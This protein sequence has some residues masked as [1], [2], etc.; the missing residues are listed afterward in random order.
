MQQKIIIHGGFFSESSANQAMKQA[1]QDALVEIV[2]KSYQYLHSNSALDTAVYAVSLLEDCE[3]FNA[4]TGSQIQADGK[5]RLSASLMDGSTKNFSGVINIESVKNP[6]QVAFKLQGEEDCVLSGLEATSFARQQGFAEYDPSTP[7]RRNEYEEKLD[8][9][10]GKGTVGCV[11][12][13]KDGNLAAATSTGGKGFERPGRVS[14]SA[15]VAGNYANELAAISCTGIGE[16]IVKG[17]LAAKIVTRVSDGASLMDACDKTLAEMK[18]YN[19][20]A[21]VIGITVDGHIHYKDSHPYMVWAF[22]DGKPVVFPG[23]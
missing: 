9:S 13:D 18:S 3:L 2:T 20:L 17:A 16:D 15:T 10:K 11:A 8:V 4:G 12:L 22:H 14:D 7:Q 1:K 5:I 6:I 19:R 23:S 21:G